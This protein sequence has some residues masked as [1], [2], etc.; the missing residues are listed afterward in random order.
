MKVLKSIGPFEYI[1]LIH[2][3]SIDTFKVENSKAVIKNFRAQTNIF[4][5][6]WKSPKTVKSRFNWY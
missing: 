6:F 1:T 4:F 5:N 2:K 3:P